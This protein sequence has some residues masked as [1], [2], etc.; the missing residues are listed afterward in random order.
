MEDA[1]YCRHPGQVVVFADAAPALIR[2]RAA[3]FRTVLITNQSGIGRGYFTEAEYREVHAE[4][5]HQLGGELLD[6]T[7]FCPDAPDISSDHRKPAP[8][9][10]F[11]AAR[12]LHLDLARS[13]VVGDKAA[14]V[15][16]AERAGLA[17]SVLV[18]TGKGHAERARCQPDFAAP[19]LTD[20]VDWIRQAAISLPPK[21]EP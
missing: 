17:G 9:M 13:Y 21:L 11:D 3:G 16:L 15:L 12:D 4:L 19:T 1:D 10:V 6:G 20:A 18:L 14:D 2:L 7:Y 5:L 8:G